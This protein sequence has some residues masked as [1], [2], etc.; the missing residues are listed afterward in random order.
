MKIRK[1]LSPMEEQVLSL[2]LDGLD[3]LQIADCM[4][5]EPKSIDNAL[6]RIRGKVRREL[7]DNQS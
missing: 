1:S 7:E 6:Q 4:G 5:R 3:Y 2:H